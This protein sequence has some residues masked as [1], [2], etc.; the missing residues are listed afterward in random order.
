M[1]D[2]ENKREE[3]LQGH[4]IRLGGSSAR[5]ER[6]HGKLY[7]WFDNFWYHHKWKTIII[8]FFTV[9]ILVCVLQMCKKEDRGDINVV[10]VGPYSFFSEESG[11]TDL[12]NCL[13]TY[14]PAD[15]DEDGVKKVD[16]IHYTVYS[17]EQIKSY[18]A[19]DAYINRASNSEEYKSFNSYVQTGEASVLFL[20]PWI[21]EKMKDKL[22]DLSVL[23]G[24]M[25][26]GAI[27]ATDAQGK[28]VCYGVRLGDTALYRENSSMQRMP[29]DTVICL[30]TPLY[31]GKNSD[32]V[33][34]AK[35]KDFIACLIG[36]E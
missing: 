8:S 18:E 10:A 21:Y 29:E 30:V 28:S 5:A 27:S 34:F 1:H 14:L 26:E 33:E 22:M 23:L 3:K 17:E 12:K 20:D 9:V 15:Y 11:I 31:F 13:A 4:E 24:Y 36:K 16:I 32:E 2:S 19:Q 7:L 25:P 6:P 35:A